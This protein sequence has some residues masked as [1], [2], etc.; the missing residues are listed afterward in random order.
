MF[1]R[2][3][4]Q[5]SARCCWVEMLDRRISSAEAYPRLRATSSNPARKRIPSEIPDVGWKGRGT[6]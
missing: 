1:H 3:N 6:G 5:G 4:A 2:S